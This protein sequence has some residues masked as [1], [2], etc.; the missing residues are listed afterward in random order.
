MFAAQTVWLP[1]LFYYYYHVFIV[2]SVVVLTILNVNTIHRSCCNGWKRY[3]VAV[4][5]VHQMIRPK[6]RG[7]HLSN[8]H[9]TA[10]PA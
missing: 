2:V 5:Y 6:R 8:A 3:G 7:E 1:V 4:A 9:S 10:Q